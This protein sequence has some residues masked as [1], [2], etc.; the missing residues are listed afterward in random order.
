LGLVF[1]VCCSMWVLCGQ[2]GE[3]L[4]LAYLWFLPMVEE[5][6]Y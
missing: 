3:L 2:I 5:L 1:R 4:F 6:L